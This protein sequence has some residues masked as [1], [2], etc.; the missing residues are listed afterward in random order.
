MTN[1]HEPATKQDLADLRHEVHQVR[2]DLRAEMKA[3]E[4]RLLEAIHDRQTD[5]LKAF[6]GYTESNQARLTTVEEVNA[7][8]KKR[9]TTLE[10]RILRVE[11]RLDLPPQSPA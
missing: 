4:E 2:D 6:Y 9:V 3:M 7:G 11:K 10:E 5:I 8:L 1:G